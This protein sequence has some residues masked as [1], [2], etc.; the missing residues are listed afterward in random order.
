MGQSLNMAY[1]I[2]RSPIAHQRVDTVITRAETS[3]LDL[4]AILDLLGIA[5]APLQRYFRI[6]IGVH[7]HVEGTISVEHW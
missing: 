1:R 5:V 7:E 3:Q 6:G 2:R 4:F